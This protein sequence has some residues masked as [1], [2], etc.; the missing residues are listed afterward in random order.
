MNDSME[1]DETLEEVVSEHIENVRPIGA[2]VTVDSPNEKKINV[3]A[4]IKLDGSKALSEATSIFINSF[5]EYLKSIVFETSSVSYAKIG[6]ILLSTA[7]VE[8]Y[9]NLLI[10][11]GSANIIVNDSEMPIAGTVTLTEVA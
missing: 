10:N 6:S 9:S 11:G 3:T 7:G 5:T 4:D 8:D 1:I 2:I